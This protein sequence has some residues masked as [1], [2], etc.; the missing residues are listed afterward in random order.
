MRTAIF[1]GLT[2]IA[3]ATRKDWITN[4]STITFMSIVMM[5]LM[6]MDI[7]DFIKDMSK[8]N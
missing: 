5:V 2:A 8:K 1:L 4:E 3:D 7:G 6:V